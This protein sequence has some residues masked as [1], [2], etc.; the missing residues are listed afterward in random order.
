MGAWTV[1]TLIYL[2]FVI[3]LDVFGHDARVD[4]PPRV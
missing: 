2:Y 3:I 4:P 1:G